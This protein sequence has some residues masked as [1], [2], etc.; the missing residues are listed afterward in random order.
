MNTRLSVNLAASI[1][2][3]IFNSL[4]LNASPQAPFGVAALIL[5]ASLLISLR[6]RSEVPHI[7][8]ETRFL[9]A[10]AKLLS[11]PRYLLVLFFVAS[12]WALN[13]QKFSATPLFISMALSH[14][15]Y[16]GLAVAV[17]SLIGLFVSLPM[18]SFIRA[19]NIKS[20]AVLSTCFL[21]Y[22]AGYGLI[23]L[24]P[25]LAGLWCGLICWSLGE[26][27]LMPQ[28]NTLIAEYTQAE[29]RLAGFSL[30]A[31]A[32]GIGEA[33]GNASGVALLTGALSWGHVWMCYANSFRGC[34][35]RVR[36]PHVC[37]PP[38]KGLPMDKKK[39]IDTHSIRSWN[40]NSQA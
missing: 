2:P 29:H 24:A 34:Y 7:Y 11:N 38:L 9:H 25:N 30:A 22:A 3:V 6:I 10:A 12:G 8:S 1:A 36:F 19:R 21:F 33:V 26:S 15:E 23:A 27:L 4:R 14:P 20:G 18:G 32:I 31:A 40:S 16:V 39:V 17:Q 5:C 13:T 35:S 28:L 37:S